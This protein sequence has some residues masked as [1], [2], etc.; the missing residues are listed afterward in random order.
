MKNAVASLASKGRVP[1]AIDREMHNELKAYSDI[2][3]VPISSVVREAVKDFIE[4]SMKSRMESLTAGKR[5]V[6]SIDS[7]GEFEP[8]STHAYIKPVDNARQQ[9]R[10]SAMGAFSFVA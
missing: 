7:V 2:T 8:D 6:V 9:S 4:T 3:G 10:P 5:N 1:V